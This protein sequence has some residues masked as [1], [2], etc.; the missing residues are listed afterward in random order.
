MSHSPK[1]PSIMPPA[2]GTSRI[3]SSTCCRRWVG[4]TE[5]Q[6]NTYPPFHQSAT[7]IQ[8]TTAVLPELLTPFYHT[9]EEDDEPAY[10]SVAVD[11]APTLRAGQ[12]FQSVSFGE[13]HAVINRLWAL[14]RRSDVDLSVGV[15][16]R[17][18]V[19]QSKLECWKILSEGARRLIHHNVLLDKYADRTDRCEPPFMAPSTN[20]DDYSRVRATNLLSM[21]WADI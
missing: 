12:S 15:A 16:H 9:I 18:L 4:R 14:K 19:T 2:S 7:P 11:A 13:E 17:F 10:A 6:D 21:A 3:L 5:A 20:P 1:S 8:V